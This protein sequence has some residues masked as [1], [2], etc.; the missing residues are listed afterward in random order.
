MAWIR[1]VSQDVPLSLLQPKPVFDNLLVS[2]SGPFQHAGH[3]NRIRAARAARIPA[4]S[5][6]SPSTGSNRPR[7]PKRNRMAEACTSRCS[8]TV[9]SSGASSIASAAS[10]SFSRADPIRKSRW[11]RRGHGA[12]PPSISLRSGRRPDCRIEGRW[13]LSGYADNLPVG[14]R[15]AFS[16]GKGHALRRRHPYAADIGWRSGEG[17]APRA[18]AGACSNSYDGRCHRSIA[19]PSPERPRIDAY[20]A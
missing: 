13:S 16:A 9:P 6:T 17:A 4:C 1:V 15:G 8:R 19:E 10:R 2:N 11:L 3:G 14:Q 12:R 18:A 20:P 7:S 5:P